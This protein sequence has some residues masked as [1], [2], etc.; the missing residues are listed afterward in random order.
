MALAGNVTTQAT[1]IRRATPQRTALMRWLAPTPRIQA[2]MQWVVETGTPSALA[3][4]IVAV[5]AVSAANPW[6]GEI[7]MIFEPIVLMMRLPPA[8]VP[9]AI[10]VAQANMTH[11]GTSK[12][13]PCFTGARSVGSNGCVP[14][15]T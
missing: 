9:N 3:V 12:V 11:W 10:A 1:T 4:R 13:L 15:V 2:L 6:S 5:P 7:L 14:A 8:A